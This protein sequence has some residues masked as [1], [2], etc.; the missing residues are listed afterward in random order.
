MSVFC[1]L[2]S[3]F[4]AALLKGIIRV[5]D[6]A[7]RPVWRYESSCSSVQVLQKEYNGGM[8]LA[9]HIQVWCVVASLCLSW[10]HYANGGC[11]PTALCS[12]S[13][14]MV[15]VLALVILGRCRGVIIW[16]SGCP[17]RA[18]CFLGRG[19]VAPTSCGQIGGHRIR[20]VW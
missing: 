11:S 1:E 16:L 2:I 9:P 15:S 17:L 3:K 5:P 19:H 14:I 7:L 8:V 20:L 12:V 6:E 10:R 4:S 13:G 18:A